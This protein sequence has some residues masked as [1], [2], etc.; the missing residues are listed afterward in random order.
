MKK[1]TILAGG[2]AAL[3][4]ASGMPSANAAPLSPAAS[5]SE[6]SSKLLLKT[7][8]DRYDDDF[9]GRRYWWWKHQRGWWGRHG[10]DR[11]RWD[12]RDYGRRGD[13][14]RADRYD[15]R[16]RDGRRWR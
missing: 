13:R 5:H 15:D 10:R 14:D 11:D 12:Y 6:A 7:H 9:R 1:S 3:V 4:M 8:G 2:F 16:D